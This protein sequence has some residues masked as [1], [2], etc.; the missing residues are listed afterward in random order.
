MENYEFILTLVALSV[1]LSIIIFPI[2]ISR[3]IDNKKRKIVKENSQRVNQLILLNNTIRFK[4]IDSCYP[5]HHQCNSKRQFESFSINDYM[6]SL[7]N[8]DSYFFLDIINSANHNKDL[9][10]FYISQ[11][12]LIKSSA[13]DENCNKLGFKLEKFLFYEEQIFNKELLSKPI[14]DVIFLCEVSFTSPQGRNH[15]SRKASYNCYQMKELI[16]RS[17][18]LNTEREQRQNQIKAERAKMSDSLRYDILKRDNFKCQIC[19]STAQDGV[20]L[21]VDHIIP[22]S[23]GGKTV[24]SNLRTLCDRCNLGKS[25]KL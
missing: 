17:K 15:Y 18:E 19:G 23:K 20:K 5:F 16:R 7:A 14:T 9:Y 1:A 2:V 4:A 22:V 8:S 13:T 11:A 10:S 6:I 24:K 3:S 25:N 21:H 12:S